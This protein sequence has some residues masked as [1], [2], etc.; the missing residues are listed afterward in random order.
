MGKLQRPL[1]PIELVVLCIDNYDGATM[2]KVT[3]I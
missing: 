2:Q 3:V 1:A